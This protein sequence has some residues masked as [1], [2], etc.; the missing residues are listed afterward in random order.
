MTAYIAYE[1]N[2]RIITGYFVDAFLGRSGDVL[3]RKPC[4]D[5]FIW[6]KP[7]E[8]IIYEEKDE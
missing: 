6:I 8:L 4:D 5:Q 1:R 2:G 3:C 7:E